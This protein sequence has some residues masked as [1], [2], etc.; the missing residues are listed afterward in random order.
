MAR[1]WMM[2][3][4]QESLPLLIRVV[5]TGTV[6]LWVLALAG[7]NYMKPEKTSRVTEPSILTAGPVEPALAVNNAGVSAST[8]TKIE[9]AHSEIEDQIGGTLEEHEI[10]TN[11]KFVI[12]KGFRGRA[13]MM[14]DACSSEVP[15]ESSPP[16]PE[17][18]RMRIGFIGGD[19]FH[20]FESGEIYSTGGLLLGRLLLFDAR[21]TSYGDFRGTPKNGA[22]RYFSA[23]WSTD[24]ETEEFFVERNPEDFP[25][26][27][28]NHGR[29][30]TVVFGDISI[31]I[32]YVR[33]F[34]MDA[35]VLKVVLRDA[36]GGS[37]VI[38]DV[39]QFGI[40]EHD[41]DADG[42]RELYLLNGLACGRWL[43]VIKIIPAVG[44]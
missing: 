23:D 32:A 38:K 41:A 2:R 12:N 15:Q 13:Y 4:I 31:D 21:G 7:C 19:G 5:R 1:P 3:R 35:N 39:R 40:V 34:C 20:V 42:I 25:Y 36:H 14:L 43:K 10:T 22:P 8:V 9:P 30:V 16:I 17:D 33:N 18:L 27:K 11:N 44:K 26:T 37:L 6:A 28:K 24:L 29:K